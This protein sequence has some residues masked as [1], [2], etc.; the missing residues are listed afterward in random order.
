MCGKRSAGQRE[1]EAAGEK[2]DF[3][4]V[5]DIACMDT[6]YVLFAERNGPRFARSNEVTSFPLAGSTA[7]TV[8]VEGSVE[9]NV[10]FSL[11]YIS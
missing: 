5:F 9:A 11:I 6:K 7:D 2:S 8:A 10:P 4:P 1:N 3:T